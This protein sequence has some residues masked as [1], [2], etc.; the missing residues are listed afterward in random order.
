VSGY[1][2]TTLNIVEYANT[3]KNLPDVVLV[4]R[5]AENKANKKRI[6]KLKRMDIQEL[7]EGDIHL[8]NKGKHNKNYDDQYD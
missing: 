1:D 2:L 4:R 5:I 8:K 7:D 6:W 3:L